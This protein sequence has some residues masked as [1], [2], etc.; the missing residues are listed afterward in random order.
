LYVYDSPGTAISV[1]AVSALV[2]H[3]SGDY[4]GPRCHYSG[5]YRDTAAVVP[6]YAVDYYTDAE[7]AN[8]I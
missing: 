8:I 2:C 6:R 3:Y 5:R 1:S 4:S 7:E